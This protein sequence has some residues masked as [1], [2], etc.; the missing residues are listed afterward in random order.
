M[1]SKMPGLG[2]NA[3]IMNHEILCGNAGSPG[4]P[5]QQ[6]FT[7][8]GSGKG[9][10]PT[11]V[12]TGLSLIVF[13]GFSAASLMVQGRTLDTC[14]FRRPS[15]AN[16]DTSQHRIAFYPCFQEDSSALV[17]ECLMESRKHGC[18]LQSASH[19]LAR[20]CMFETLGKGSD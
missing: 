9:S 8:E 3:F 11:L 15:I 18:I 4:V 10:L 5:P 1:N 19:F 16:F 14:T 6:G 2:N 13:A 17:R 20:P 12:F 7:I